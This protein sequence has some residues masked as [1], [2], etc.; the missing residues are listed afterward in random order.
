MNPAS[1]RWF[2]RPFALF[3]DNLGEPAQ[4]G[5]LEGL[6]DCI[7]AYTPEEVPLALAAIEAAR[8]NGHWLALASSYELGA[9]LEATLHATLPADAGTT[10]LLRAWVFARRTLLERDALAPFWAAAL[11]NLTPPEQEACLL[12][13][14]PAWDAARHAEACRRILDWIHAGDCYQVNLT[15]PLSGQAG[16]HPLALFARLRET[17]PVTHG[18]LIFDGQDWILSR[19]PELFVTRRGA[20]LTCRPMK[21]TAARSADAREDAARAAALQASTKDRA[22]NLMIVDLIRNDLGRLAPAGGVRVERLFELEAYRSLYQLTSTVSAAPVNATLAETLAALFPCGSVTG[23][24]KIRAMQIIHALEDGPRGLYCGALGW[25]APDGDFSLN[26][27]I[28]TLLLDKE[29]HLRLDVGSGIVADSSPADEYRECLSKASFLRQLGSDLQLIETLRC[30]A[31]IYP[32]LDRHLM[33]LTRS[34][35]ELGFACDPASLSRTLLEFAATLPAEAQRVRL[36]LARDGKPTLQAAVQDALPSGQRAALAPFTLASTDP[37]LRHKTTARRF[38]DTALRAAMADG[39]FDLIF[40]NERGELCEGARSNLFL[41]MD[42]GPLRT[43]AQAC[44]LLPGVLRAQLLDEGRAIE[45][46]LRQED[47][48]KAR[49]IWLGNALRGLVEVGVAP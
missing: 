47:L 40:S 45:A 23:A 26:V 6:L 32:L 28:R 17:Q 1:G 34:A 27:P 16:G 8:K 24:P 19:S 44:G 48:F 3:E 37:R 25:L 31:G 42:D 14:Q 39:L 38:Y 30:E 36:T 21:G 46:V 33:R 12:S 5:L 11:A 18:A 29:G 49:R 10:P 13:L 15:F 4:L 35:R 20:Q 2:D 7:C 9:A 43:P 22:E 41:E